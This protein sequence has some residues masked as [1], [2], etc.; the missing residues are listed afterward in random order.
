MKIGVVSDTHI[1][2]KAR[3]LPANLIEA[4]SSVELIIH[5]GDIINQSVLDALAELAPVNAVYGNIDP[6]ELRNVLPERLDLNLQG[7]QIGVIHGHN[8]RGHIM[9][10]LSY[11]FPE[12]DII[13]FGHTHRPCNQIINGQLYF[14]PGS[15]T[16][17]RLQPKYSFGIIELG[18]RIISN[19]VEF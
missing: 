17:R 19:I 10:K 6:P 4:F 7:Y 11:I 9:D 15:P 1:P 16:D 18:D 8:L 13:I 5:A 3:N 12:S 14:N 2:T